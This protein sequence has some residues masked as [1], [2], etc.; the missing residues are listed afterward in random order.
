MNL[1]K[2]T[3]AQPGNLGLWNEGLTQFG[4]P[5]LAGPEFTALAELRLIW[6]DELLD[7]RRLR[8]GL[9]CGLRAPLGDGQ[10][11]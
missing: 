11:G 8:S 7:E 10:T 5:Y 2:L 3:S 9:C 6:Q 1:S 4:G